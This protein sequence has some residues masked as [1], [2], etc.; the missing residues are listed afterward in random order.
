LGARSPVSAAPDP[1][2]QG[3]CGDAFASGV[4]REARGLFAAITGHLI[5]EPERLLEAVSGLGHELTVGRCRPIAAI[6]TNVVNASNAAEAIVKMQLE[7][8]ERLLPF[9]HLRIPSPAWQS[10]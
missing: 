7:I 9:A 10:L 4:R 8:L 5:L 2:G 6:R 3:R 1:G